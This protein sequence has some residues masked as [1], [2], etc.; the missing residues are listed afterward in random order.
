MGLLPR[1][2]PAARTSKASLWATRRPSLLRFEIAQIR[3]LLALLGA[4]EV[5]F[6]ALEIHIV[7]D[8][9][10]S[11]ALHAHIL[12]PDRELGFLAPVFFRNRPRARQSMVNDRHVVVH[13]VG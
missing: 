12:G 8:E 3:R 1:I 7:A 13:E 2:D 10:E 6:P 9:D 4:H 11:A 5:P